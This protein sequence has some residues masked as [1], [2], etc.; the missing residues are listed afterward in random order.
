MSNDV[1]HISA[2]RG[3]EIGISFISL[4]QVLRAGFPDLHREIRNL[5]EGSVKVT[6]EGVYSLA[7]IQFH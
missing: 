2:A 3:T 4:Y 1:V 5:I 6:S 7:R